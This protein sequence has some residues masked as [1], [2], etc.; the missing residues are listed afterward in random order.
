MI[1]PAKVATTRYRYR[2]TV[3]PTPWPSLERGTTRR[4]EPD[5]WSARCSETGT[6]DAEA[7]RRNGS[8]DKT[9]TALQIDFT[10]HLTGQLANFAADNTDWLRIVR[11]STHAPELNPAEGVW[12]L[13]RRALANFAVTDLPGLVRIVLLRRLP[14]RPRRLAAT[15][16]K[17]LPWKTRRVSQR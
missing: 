6:P 1:N 17:G 14:V 5:L 16:S 12:S 2:R 7:V 8:V 9:G 3:I 15:L 4:P 11:L 10:V 13:L